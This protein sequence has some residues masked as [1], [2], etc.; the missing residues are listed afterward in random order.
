MPETF[1]CPHCGADVPVGAPAC[2]ICGSDEETGWSDRADYA[3]LLIYDDDE[4]A[5]PTPPSSGRLVRQ[6][7]VAAVA[8]IMVLALVA[9]SSPWVVYLLPIFLAIIALLD[10]RGRVRSNTGRGKH[11]YQELLMRAKG[12]KA[13]V[14]RLVAYERKRDPTAGR[15]QLLEDALYRWEQDNR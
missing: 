5:S 4:E 7:I 9:S 11:L 3:H 10:Y 1:V 13:L 12:D 2:P 6:Y 14:E 15:E 8:A